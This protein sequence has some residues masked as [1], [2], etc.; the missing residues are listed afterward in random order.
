M[1]NDKCGFMG[2]FS[3]SLEQFCVDDRFL[4]SYEDNNTTS[5]IWLCVSDLFYSQERRLAI[6]FGKPDETFWIY[7][8]FA[9]DLN[10]IVIIYESHDSGN[11]YVGIGRVD[12]EAARVTIENSVSMAWDL[13]HLLNWTAQSDP[14]N[15][16][17][18]V[19]LQLDVNDD[20]FYATFKMKA[21]GSLELK[22]LDLTGGMKLIGVFDGCLYG[23]LFNNRCNHMPLKLKAVSLETG[24]QIEKLTINWDI[25]NV[26]LMNYYSEYVAACIGRKAVIAAY[27]SHKKKTRIC[28]L[29]LK[30][31]KWERTSVE[32]AGHVFLLHNNKN[33]TLIMCEKYV[34]STE[35]NFYRFVYEPDRLS[36]CAWLQLKRIFDSVPGSHDY[37][38]SQLPSNFKPRCP[39]LMQP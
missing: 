22:Q 12:F 32:L 34:H 35:G 9:I 29:D 28:E 26:S 14:P 21:D 11:I 6:D 2:K 7:G 3:T 30:T 15:L 17:D 25:L 33:Q 16:H 13:H 27:N 38:L 10:T 8:L 4:F 24:E 39:F 31:L 37:I 19:V 23:L 5:T 36:D 20:F 18:G 1:E